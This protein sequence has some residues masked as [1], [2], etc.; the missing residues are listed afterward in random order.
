MKKLL[1]ITIF[2]LLFSVSLLFGGFFPSK[3]QLAMIERAFEYEFGKPT[4]A[5]IY[6]FEGG[7]NYWSVYKPED[8]YELEGLIIVYSVT[9]YEE[10][11]RPYTVI[12][13]YSN[14][15]ISFEFTPSSLKIATTILNDQFEETFSSAE[16]SKS[17]ENDDEWVFE[18]Y[19]YFEKAN[20]EV[21]IAIFVKPSFKDKWIVIT[22]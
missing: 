11:R 13:I 8:L 15:P 5:D 10:W 22:E 3:S 2:F 9:I 17:I 16:F 14:T 7:V 18:K 6:V 4:A 21:K 19:F 12:P 1:F 20:V